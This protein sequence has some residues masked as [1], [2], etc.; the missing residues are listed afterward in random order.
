MDSDVCEG[1]CVCVGMCID[2]YD[3]NDCMFKR[4]SFIKSVYRRVLR[5][6]IC[7]TKCGFGYRVEIF[8]QGYVQ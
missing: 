1:G 8:L 3:C 6:N 2:L 7:I 5:K 4:R